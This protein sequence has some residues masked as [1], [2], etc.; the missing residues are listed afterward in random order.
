VRGLALVPYR[1]VALWSFVAL[2]TIPGAIYMVDW[3]RDTVRAG[4]QVR[5]LQPGENAALR[6]LHG[7][8]EPGGVLTNANFGTLVPAATGRQSWVGHPSWTRDYAARATEVEQLF[9]GRLPSAQAA[10]LVRESGARYVFVGCANA[11][12]AAPVLQPLSSG[13]RRFGCAIVY[14]VTS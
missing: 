1:V 7:S 8:G 9:G 4:G 3:F 10:A 5:Y 11:L 12:T 6:Y 2:V 13:S 14:R